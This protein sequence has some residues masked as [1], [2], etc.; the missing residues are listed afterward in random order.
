MLERFGLWLA[1]KRLLDEYADAFA[2]HS[3]SGRTPELERYWMG[4]MTAIRR[5]LHP[6]NREVGK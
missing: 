6:E 1:R 3:L 2:A 5:L 4:R